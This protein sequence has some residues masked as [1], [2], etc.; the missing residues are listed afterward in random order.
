MTLEPE[1]VPGLV[2]RAKQLVAQITRTPC[3]PDK[4]AQH[5]RSRYLHHEDGMLLAAVLCVDAAPSA[6]S[7]YG[8]SEEGCR[9]RLQ[10]LKSLVDV[11]T[12]L[13]LPPAHRHFVSLFL[14]SV[15]DK[16]AVC[17]EQR[18]Q[19]D[20]LHT[21]LPGVTR[22]SLLFPQDGHTRG[23]QPPAMKA[24]TELLRGFGSAT[25]PLRVHLYDVTGL[26]LSTSPLAEAARNKNIWLNGTGKDRSARL[27]YHDRSGAGAEH[28]Q[29]KHSRLSPEW[30]TGLKVHDSSDPALFTS[31]EGACIHAV[32]LPRSDCVLGADHPAQAW[33]KH[34]QVECCNILES[35]PPLPLDFSNAF[36]GKTF[37]QWCEV[38][39]RSKEK[40]PHVGGGHALHVVDFVSPSGHMGMATKKDSIHQRPSTGVMWSQWNTFAAALI[41]GFA[42]PSVALTACAVKRIWPDNDRT[43]WCRSAYAPHGDD[44]SYPG[45]KLYPS[46]DIAALYPVLL[47]LHPDK[48]STFGWSGQY[49]HC[50]DRDGSLPGALVT[51]GNFTG[52]E[53][54]LLPFARLVR[55]K[56]GSVLIGRFGLLQHAVRA[57]FLVQGKGIR[58]LALVHLHTD[59][60]PPDQ[61]YSE[62]PSPGPSFDGWAPGFVQLAQG[63]A[64]SIAG[65]SRADSNPANKKIDFTTINYAGDDKTLDRQWHN[66]VLKPYGRRRLEQLVAWHKP[67]AEIRG[68]WVELCG[69]DHAEDTGCNERTV[70]R[71]MDL[72]AL[73]VDPVILPA[74]CRDLTG[75]WSSR[76]EECARRLRQLLAAAPEEPGPSSSGKRSRP[77][78]GGGEWAL[79]TA[80]RRQ[81]R[82]FA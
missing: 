23:V 55:C 81:W 33:L 31:H 32:S 27:Y 11:Q 29:G 3:A 77:R 57:G 67:A 42:R 53:Q 52:Y 66:G 49:N 14:R 20:E 12:A 7:V 54:A 44:A 74:M 46:A 76:K 79:G 50:D 37:R 63:C 19:L 28:V 61:L 45:V 41:Y 30:G 24:S 82:G 62:G 65:L 22:C 5:H 13:R 64:D 51:Y 10:G 36:R 35:K 56:H 9:S 73:L 71:D 18:R 39:T 43:K 70:V 60:V 47:R 21:G 17:F 75:A 6:P 1:Q 38:A 80:E 25:A 2:D 16:G 40:P 68:A 34:L 8:R 69:K 15:F 78:N 72:L 48:T 26:P 4:T 59:M 58:L